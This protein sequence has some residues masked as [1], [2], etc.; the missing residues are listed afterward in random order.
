PKFH[1]AST[2]F[3]TNSI[4]MW[5]FKHDSSSVWPPEDITDVKLYFNIFNKLVTIPF[6]LNFLYYQ[7]DNTVA[8]GFTMQDA[9]NLEFKGTEFN[10]KFKKS[11]ITFE[12]FPLNTDAQMT[13]T[14]KLSLDYSSNTDVC[15]F[16]FQI[17]EVTGTNAKLVNRINYTD[18]G[19]NT[20]QRKTKLINGISHSHIFKA[21][22]KVRIV[23][24]NLDT[25]PD[26]LSFLSTNPYV[27]PVLK[28]GKHKLYISN[29]S[30]ISFP[31]KSVSD[32]S[33]SIFAENNNELTYKGEQFKLH[34][35]YPN[36]FNPVTKIS[37]SIPQ[38]YN[39]IVTLK[40]YDITGKEISSLVNNTINSNNGIFE[41]SWDGSKFASG[42]YFYKLTAGNFSD[43]KK[44]ILVK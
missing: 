35:N 28:N 3:P 44:M 17:Y 20:N 29:N 25:A 37:F 39:G 5:S 38:N 31:V 19:Y 41:I 23:V 2:T 10:S 14:P 6:P 12:T 36:P 43:I 42:V 15:Q 1:Y 26:D 8:S 9:V 30:Y 7:L 21:G 16:N 24:T 34:Q 32:F 18:R 33:G 13:G 11:S 27:L 4:G 40:V 22:S